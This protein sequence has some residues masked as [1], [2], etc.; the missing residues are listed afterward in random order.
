M[1]QWSHPQIP[2]DLLPALFTRQ[3]CVGQFPGA[4]EAVWL[5]VAV[6]GLGKLDLCSVESNSNLKALQVFGQ[7]GEE[8]YYY[9]IINPNL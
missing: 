2:V 1:S 8:E 6:S 9:L 5:F 4:A 3:W 7:A